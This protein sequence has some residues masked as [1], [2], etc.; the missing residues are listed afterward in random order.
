MAR[1]RIRGLGKG[2]AP[3]QP[4]R[5]G[6][7]RAVRLRRV[8]LRNGHAILQ[9]ERIVD[10][11]FEALGPQMRSGLRIDQLARDTDYCIS[12]KMN[13]VAEVR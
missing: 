13:D 6:H 2:K 4:L 10:P 9:L 7:R 3:T 11:T 8:E 12:Q 5:P 1:R